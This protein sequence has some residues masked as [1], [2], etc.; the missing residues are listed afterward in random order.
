MIRQT[1]TNLHFVNDAI[2]A[3]NV[4]HFLRVFRRVLSDPRRLSTAGKSAH[5]HH[6]QQ[7]C[8]TA[9]LTAAMY[10]NVITIIVI[11]VSKM[12]ES[13]HGHYTNE[14]RVRKWDELST[15]FNAPPDIS[16]MVFTA[17]HLTV[18]DKQTIR[19]ILNINHKKYTHKHNTNQRK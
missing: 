11:S 8:T 6:L 4:V 14:R 16:E 17:N 7:P 1:Q 2:S 13:L 18:T 19:K 3:E 5:H 12:T 10:C 15:E 9:V